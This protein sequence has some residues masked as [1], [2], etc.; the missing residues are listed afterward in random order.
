MDPE[1]V[2]TD[3]ITQEE[4]QLAARNH[5]MPLEALRY[6]VTP[7]GLH[8]LLIHFDIPAGRRDDVAVEVGGLRRAAA[9][10]SLA[11]LRRAARRH[12]A[13]DDGVRRQR[14]R[15]PAPAAAQPAVARRGRSARPS[16]PARRSRRSCARPGSRRRRVELVFTGADRGVQ[17]GVE[18]DY[19]RSLP[20]A[21]A[22]RDD[23]LLAYEMNG[24]P[25][26]PAARLP[27]AAPRAGLVRHDER[28]VAADGSTAVAEPFDGLPAVGVR[29]PRRTR[30][31][32]ARRSRA[33]S[34]AR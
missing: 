19:E 24:E 27:A 32:P 6:D 10:L 25:L 16:G 33:S 5:G 22:L 1:Q 23:V 26:P 17:G 29:D 8:Y 30:T 2:P 3:G 31:T 34:R 20:V 14:P 21:E 15:A 28:E 9:V 18:H 4:L 12:D 11:D 7:V 13:G